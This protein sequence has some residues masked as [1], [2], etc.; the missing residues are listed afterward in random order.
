MCCASSRTKRPRAPAHG[1]GGWAR[2]HLHEQ[3]VLPVRVQRGDGAARA[4]PDVGRVQPPQADVRRQQHALLQLGQ[5]LEDA[6]AQGGVAG[7]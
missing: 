2:T 1:G 5:L 3:V 4:E 6:C 7:C